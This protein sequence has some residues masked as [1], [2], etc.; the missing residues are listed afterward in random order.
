MSRREGI[1]QAA[2]Q[3]FAQKGFCGTAVSEIAR[4]AGVAQG[5]VFHHFKNKQ[6][7]LAAICEG[8][9]R[10]YTQGIQEAASGEGTG[11]E[12]VERVLRFSQEFRKERSQS[13]VVALR[14]TGAEE[15]RNPSLHEHFKGLL[16]KVVEVK[17]K[18]ILQGL[19]DGSIRAAPPYETALI[20][21]ALL[22]GVVFMDTQKLLPFP[23]LD[24]D[25]LEF[26]RRSLAA[27]EEPGGGM[28][29]SARK[30]L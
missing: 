14:E 20:I 27:G 24:R 22:T 15:R 29:Q 19:A 11:W 21:Q 2:T 4:K 26:C 25:V 8:M 3:L 13:L 16:E 7:L 5:T 10:E 1:I 17:E 30:I 28:T 18:C 12:A 6:N 23:D 9:I